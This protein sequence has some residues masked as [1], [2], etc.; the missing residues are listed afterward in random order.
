MTEFHVLYS[1]LAKTSF[2]S[3]FFTFENGRQASQKYRRYFV[4]SSVVFLAAC[5]CMFT[6]S[7]CLL[8]TVDPLDAVRIIVAVSF[9]LIVFHSVY[10]QYRSDKIRS[11]LKGVHAVTRSLT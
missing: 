3:G 9:F 2:W 10:F 11:L 5:S 6:S 8:V 4:M 7:V 1:S